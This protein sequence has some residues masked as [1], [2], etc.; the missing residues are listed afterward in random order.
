[1]ETSEVG[2]SALLPIYVA[3]RASIPERGKMW[4]HFRDEWRVP[5]TSTWIDED[6]D[7]ATADFS[8]LWERI[9]KEVRVANAVVLYAET[10]DFP[11]KGALIEVGIALGM[12]KR[13]VVCLPDVELEPRSCRPIG[14]WVNHPLVSRVDDVAGAVKIASRFT[15]ES[16]TPYGKLLNTHDTLVAENGRLVAQVDLLLTVAKGCFDYGG[17]Y[18]ADDEKLKIFHHGIQTVINALAAAMEHGLDDT[19]VAALYCA[20]ARSA[21]ERKE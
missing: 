12:N 17:G 15:F 6:G 11:L 5:I 16:D 8:E 14:S 18:R 13:V 9:T 1:M 7:G 10:G 4:R 3:S 19:Q 2:A 21:L 20:G